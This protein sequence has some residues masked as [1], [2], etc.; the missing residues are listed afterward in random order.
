[1][2]SY[3]KAV[4]IILLSVILGLTVGK[5]E[6]S[7]S[8]LLSLAAC[9]IVIIV[10]MDYLGPVMDLL[11]ELNSLGQLQHGIL[12]ILMKITG[13]TVIAEV[14]GM[15]CG[16]AGNESLKKT[17]NLLTCAVVLYLSVPIFR[18]WI[19]LIQDILGEIS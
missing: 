10:A 4:A 15:I 18:T 11:W 7:L 1:M 16:D 3:W 8:M 5:N 17:L 19:T 6:K 13:I 9:C 14:T 12:G 2:E